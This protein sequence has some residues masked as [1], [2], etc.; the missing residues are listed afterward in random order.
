MKTITSMLVI[1]VFIYI[2]YKRRIS[3]LLP[4]NKKKQIKN[5]GTDTQTKDTAIQPTQQL[6]T[7]RQLPGIPLYGLTLD[8][9][10]CYELI[11]YDYLNEDGNPDACFADR[12]NTK[13]NLI[14][15]EMIKKGYP[16]RIDFITVGPALLFL[17]TYRVKQDSVTADISSKMLLN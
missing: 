6:F 7:S 5:S 9:D 14:S 3:P 13:L 1:A 2:V 15:S 10:I 17:V 4:K 12:I 11:V 8:P 16:Y